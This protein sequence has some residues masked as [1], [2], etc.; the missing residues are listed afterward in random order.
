MMGALVLAGS[1]EFLPT[2]RVVDEVV[3]RHAP[4]T[5]PRAAIV[6]TASGLE[7]PV[8]F[9]W[10]ARGV[11]HF[12][13]LGCTAFGVPILGRDDADSPEHVAALAGADL[14]YLPGG[15]PRHLVESLR[16]TA[17]WRAIHAAWLGGAI[18]A[19]SSAGAMA[20][21][22][23]TVT[24][25]AQ[26]P[27][28]LPALGLLPG[29]GILPHYDRFGGARSGPLAA[30][31]PPHLAILGIDED[32]VVLVAGG[33]ATVLGASTVTLLRDNTATVFHTGERLP[34]DVVRVES[35]K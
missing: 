1:G 30:V 17:A 35:R 13:A 18:L 6:P 3:L 29:L 19:G 33:E 11:A 24:P 2:M 15:N 10:I 23:L 9:D 12:T 5:S 31:A 22:E 7:G 32:T 16:E 34:R 20:L 14:I 4:H 27:A 26:A 21:G 28:W 25:R 8:P